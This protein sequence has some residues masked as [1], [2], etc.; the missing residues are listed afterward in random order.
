MSL[1]DRFAD[2]SSTSA[3]NISYL[4]KEKLYSIITAERVQTKYGISVVLTIKSS[5]QDALRVFL[6]KYFTL[7]FSVV[8]M[9]MMNKEMVMINQVYHDTCQKSSVYL[10][11][12]ERVNNTD[13]PFIFRLCSHRVVCIILTRK[14]PYRHMLVKPRGLTNLFPL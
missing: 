13:W 5:S 3:V 14:I 10:L 7:I 4:E 9:D 12:L 6:P 1:Y 2:V 8:D 11:S